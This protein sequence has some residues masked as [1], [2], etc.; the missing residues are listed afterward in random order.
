MP[1]KVLVV[2]DSGFF[3]RRL[4]EILV[5]D[6]LIKVV[7]SAANGRE[8]IDQV[9]ALQPDVV[10]MDVEMPIMD[11]ITAVKEIMR[12]H[13]TPILMFSSL[14]NEGAQATLDAL[15]AGAID[16]LPKKFEDIA[17][18]RERALAELRQRVYLIG[19]RGLRSLPTITP[20]IKTTAP[21]ITIVPTLRLRHDY[22]LVV[23][24]SSTGGPLA[25]QEILTRLPASFPLPLLLIQHMPAN[26]T[27]T[28]A[29]RLDQLCQVRVREA[30]HGDF[31]LRG[32]A[33]LA[34]GGKQMTLDEHGIKILIRESEPGLN[35][36]PSVDI[37]FASA[38]RAF[39]GQVL[40]L[41][42]TGMGNDGREGAR[43]LKQTNST[44]WA[45]NEAS[46]VV[47]GMP[48]AIVEDGLADQILPLSEI[49][50]AL[51]NISS[52]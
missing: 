5:A 24:G 25:L 12:R 46:C 17:N 26:F 35:Y 18:E 29:A 45:Q 49:G 13:P 30:Q 50:S 11:G 20:A 44:V 6:P 27:P 9:I 4:T 39:P 47:Y 34:P 36:R 16:F 42:L 10:T 41:V 33:L 32:T 43:L 23:I 40:A 8:A 51:T 1:V 31:I 22:R 38:A 2:D 14:T 19:M 28:F 7:G 3:R 15:E 52:K 37:T 48:M 21:L